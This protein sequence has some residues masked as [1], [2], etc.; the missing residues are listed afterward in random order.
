MNEARGRT[1]ETV[2][3][4][5]A[6][7]ACTLAALLVVGPLVG[8]PRRGL[9]PN[10]GDPLF[11]LYVM[12]WGA[13]QMSLG[14]PDLWNAPF[15]HPTRG[16]LALSDPLIGPAAGLFALR[17]AG[18]P[19]VA[20][21]NALF[22][23]T[24]VLGAWITAW[25]LRRSGRSWPGALI[26]GWVFS[27]SS[28]RWE[29]LGHYQMLRMQWLP[30]LLFSFDR[31]LEAPSA[32]RAAA[33]VSF[34]ALHVS[35]GTYLAYLVHLALLVLLLNRFP[36]G[37]LGQRSAWLAWGPAA[38][39]CGGLLALVFGPFVAHET[40]LRT[41]FDLRASGMN[42]L[43][44]VT[45]S[46]LSVMH[47]VVPDWLRAAGRG[48]LYPGA[49][50][51]TL[52]G[53]ALWSGGRRFLRPP[54]ESRRTRRMGAAAL[55]AAGAVGV[56]AGL[57]AGDRFTLRGGPDSGYALPLALTLAG[58]LALWL[59][60]RAT[61]GGPCLRWGQMPVWPRGLILAGA[62]AVPLCLPMVFWGAGHLLPGL[63]GMRVSARAFALAS[64]PLAY[65]AASGWDRLWS[66]GR[67]RPLLRAVPLL[68]AVAAVAE[69]L[70]RGERIRWWP[71]PDEADFPAYARFIAA[72]TAVK[73]YLELPP[74]RVPSGEVVAMY[75]QTLHW[76]PLVN[77]YSGHVPPSAREIGLLLRPLPDVLG[78]R[79][80]KERGITHVVAHWEALP[81][82]VGPTRR[83]ALLQRPSFEAAVD[84]VGGRPVFV[85]GSTVVYALSPDEAG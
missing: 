72:S 27:Y 77:G 64:L 16:T 55:A 34:Y 78:L 4:L 15:F 81:W 53:V 2:G 37:R 83:R 51:M 75:F 1:S 69:G 7:A 60:V 58:V 12:K 29:H 54:A 57:V 39:A 62:V 6:L 76:R 13:H 41:V 50:A 49:A 61:W 24:W 18:V 42:L 32:G 56:A 8:D 38:V 46:E 68:L 26:G 5:L 45:P 22:F 84:E 31:L 67:G 66:L 65:L 71:V 74:S 63:A 17:L 3:V 73:A 70:P 36:V 33:F 10:L 20:A 43:G 44:F 25:V 85:D 80:L 14:L 30:A 52:A 59:A 28:F 79:A 23:A 82:H 11:N 40:P 48:C 47:T 35:G 21:F 19:S 9:G